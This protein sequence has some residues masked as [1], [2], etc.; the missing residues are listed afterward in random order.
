MGVWFCEMEIN[1]SKQWDELSKTGD[2][3]LRNCVDCGKSVH[4]VDSQEQLEDAA[5][6]GKCVAF[7]NVSDQAIPLRDRIQLR[8]KWI[9]NKPSDPNKVSLMTLGLPRSR[10]SNEKIQSF[11]EIMNEFEKQIKK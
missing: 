5:R 7:Y 10:S 3:L 2:T 4:F 9:E 1:C 6:N 8:R 11:D